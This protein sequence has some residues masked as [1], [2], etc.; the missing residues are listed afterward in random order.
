WLNLC[1]HGLW[2]VA[3][4]SFFVLGPVIAQR[5]LGGAGSWGLVASGLSAG[6]I[7]GG[8]VALRIKP[9]RPLV[10]ANLALTLT[11]AQLLGL[12]VPL[13]APWLAALGALGFC[14]V[15]FLNAVWASVVQQRIPRETLSR[16]SAYDWLISLVA[17]PAGYALAGPLSA[18]L[19]TATTLVGASLFV[20]LPSLATALTPAIRRVR[21]VEAD[22]AGPLIE[23]PTVGE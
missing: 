13:P 15:A 8:M 11:V 22:E 14:G 7:A 6:Y 9:R 2:N 20:L 16:V 1:S 21:Y 4:A 18:R 12:A 5:R 17:M 3:I 23:A 19:G 10:W